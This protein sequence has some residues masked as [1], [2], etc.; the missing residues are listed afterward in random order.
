M[1]RSRAILF[2]LSILCTTFLACQDDRDYWDPSILDDFDPVESYWGK[3]NGTCTMIGVDTSG[4]TAYCLRDGDFDYYV[5][6]GKGNLAH[7]TC[8]KDDQGERM[9]CYGAGD[10]QDAECM[11]REEAMH[12]VEDGVV[13]KS[14]LWNEL[15][16]ERDAANMGTD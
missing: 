15:R 14:D 6:Q 12:D 10:E 9:V 8:P 4:K 1:V 2:G 7:R 16:E 5:C 11:P 3:Y 13:P